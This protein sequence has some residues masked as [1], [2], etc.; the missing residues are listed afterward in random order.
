MS[1]YVENLIWIC[2]IY[3]RVY[4]FNIEMGYISNNADILYPAVEFT[5]LLYFIY[6]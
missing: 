6:R 3:L 4:V 1:S 2:F 5:N